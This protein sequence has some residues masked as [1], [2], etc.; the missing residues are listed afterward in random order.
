M[1]FVDLDK[2]QVNLLINQRTMVADLSIFLAALCDY[3]LGM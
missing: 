3:L 1:I 2:G